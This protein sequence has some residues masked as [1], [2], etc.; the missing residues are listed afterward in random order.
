MQSESVPICSTE[1]EPFWNPSMPTQKEASCTWSPG[2]ETAGST[3]DPLT[4]ENWV[5]P[6]T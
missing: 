2:H 1:F 6:A 4:T 5:P 3:H